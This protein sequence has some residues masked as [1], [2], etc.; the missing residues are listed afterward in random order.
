MHTLKLFKNRVTAYS[1][2]SLA[3]LTN[4]GWRPARH[5]LKNIQI[6]NTRFLSVEGGDL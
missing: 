2:K 5:T 4:R 6:P 1:V 3:I